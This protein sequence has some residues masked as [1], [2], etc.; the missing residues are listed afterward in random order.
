MWAEDLFG[1]SS[2]DSIEGL[3]GDFL[4]EGAAVCRYGALESMTSST[5]AEN[6]MS[7]IQGFAESFMLGEFSCPDLTSFF[8]VSYCSWNKAED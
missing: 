3:E 5:R 4:G 6:L 2:E 7:L 8:R 1:G